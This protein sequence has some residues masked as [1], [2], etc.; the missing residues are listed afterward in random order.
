MESSSR[1][2]SFIHTLAV[3]IFLVLGSTALL[4]NETPQDLVKDMVYNELTANKH[5][6]YWMYRDSD[7]Q[8]GKTKISRVVE[9][10]DCWFRWVL[11]VNGQ[12]LTTSQ[13]REQQ[14]KINQLVSSAE[15]REK[16]RTAILQDGNKA[17]NLVRMLTTIF[18]YT[19]EGEQN[20]NIRL[21]FR[22]NPQFNPPTDAAKVFHHMQG[23]LLINAR[24]KR[25]A[26]ISGTLMQDVTFGWGILGRLYRGGIFHVMQT[27]LSPGDWE[28]TTLDVH[29]HGRAL[30]FKTIS[31][32]QTEVK[33]SFEPVPSG[34]TL[35]K[36]AA[37]AEHGTENASAASK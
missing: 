23:T 12:P 35:A 32:E 21:Q 33:T 2:K 7:T 20:G 31:E 1:K 13:Q 28:V 4:A 8:S 29:I 5:Q 18:L 27:Q 10:S 9:T 30:F 17:E 16:N 36:A 25:L 6:N 11:S 19:E 26:G 22:P 24:E 34:I 14:A 3:F 37:L 15:A